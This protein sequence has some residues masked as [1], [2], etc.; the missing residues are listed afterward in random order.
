MKPS[1]SIPH[2]ESFSSIIFDFGNVICNINPKLTEQ[3]F[4]ALGL[5]SFDTS[6]SISASKGL[7]E[8]LE[9][10][11]ITPE[12]F[13]DGLRRFFPTTLTNEQLDHAW[14]ALLLDIP[15]PRIRLLEKLR[16]Q[17]RIFLLSNS[18]IIHYNHYLAGFQQEYGYVG[19]DALFE[20]AWFS[21][22]IGLKKPDLAIFEFVIAQGNLI[23]SE[24]LFIDDTLQHVE[25]ARKAGIR[26]Y[27]LKASQG[28]QVTNLFGFDH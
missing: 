2:P 15:A 8:Q 19:F 12:D 27:H 24:T 6:L 18:N 21:F 5:K 26:G 28:E 10:G 17:Y 16:T 9:T 3:A 13:R 14:N 4:I 25:G 11:T 23:P 7:F 20:K 1:S 22:D